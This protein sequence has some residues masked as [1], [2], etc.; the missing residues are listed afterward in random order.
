LEETPN[1]YLQCAKKFLCWLVRDRRTASSPLAHL[2]GGNVNLDRRHDRRELS[3]KEIVP[4]QV[5]IVAGD[6]DDGLTACSMQ[7]VRGDVVLVW[8]RWL[9]AQRSPVVLPD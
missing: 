5:V 9:L 2:Q 6:G 3:P 8:H 4:A 1:F 7:P